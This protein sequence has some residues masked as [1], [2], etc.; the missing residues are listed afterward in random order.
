MSHVKD[1]PYQDL[2]KHKAKEAQTCDRRTRISPARR[3]EQ[4]HLS[5]DGPRTSDE[6]KRMTYKMPQEVEQLQQSSSAPGVEITVN[7]ESEDIV[8]ADFRSNNKFVSTEKVWT[9]GW[10][11]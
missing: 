2:L 6:R 3:F 8:D 1:N 10:L 11:Y 5:S 7:D 4:I 9:Y